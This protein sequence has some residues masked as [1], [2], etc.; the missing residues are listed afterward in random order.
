MATSQKILFVDLTSGTSRVDEVDVRGLLGLGG[1]ALG[2][3]LLERYLDPKADPLAPEN[4]VAITPSLLAG[5][6]MS[7]SNRFGAFTRSPLTGIWLESYCG[8][9][10]ARNFRETGWDALVLSG[11]AKNPTHLHITAEGPS[12]LPADELWGK[13]CFAAEDELLSHLGRRSSVLCIGLA[14]ERQVRVASVM[15]QHAHSLGRGGLGAVFGSKSLKAVSV[16]SPGPVR[17]EVHDHFAR[18]RKEVAALAADSPTT[19]TYRRFGTPVM[20]ALVNEAGAFPTDFFSKGRAPHRATLEA[21]RWPEWAEIHSESCPPCAVR[22]RKRLTMKQGPQAGREMHAPEF[23]TLYTFG[24]SCMVRHAA[25]VARLNELCNILGLDTMSTGNLV[26]AAIKA[27]ELGRVDGVPAPGDVAGISRLLSEIASRST[28]LGEALAQGMDE[29]LAGFG[30]SD[31]SITSKHLDPAGYEPRRLR[32]MALSNALSVRGACHLRATYYKAE[33]GGLLAELDDDAFVQTYIDWEDRMLISDSLT[34]CRFYR[35][36]M[37]W[38]RLVSAASQLNGTPLTKGELER[39]S[40]ETVTRIRRLNLA[41]GCTPADDTVAERFF[42]EPTD[43]APAVD[44]EELERQV[45]IYWQKR[46]WSADGLVP[47]VSL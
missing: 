22:C 31:W 17:S 34:L 8:G 46:G 20:V 9:T 41:F 11:S 47:P 2:V 36:F 37:T 42:R 5:Y 38:D 13:D 32:S 24:G 18:T 26:A 4:V 15:H 33:L 39:L 21:E 35:D 44:R 27:G 19:T 1:K 3:R 10:F 7:G 28:P 45:R 23:E 25:D 12:L 30:M 6:A 43:T 14:G 29:A 40:T 16:T